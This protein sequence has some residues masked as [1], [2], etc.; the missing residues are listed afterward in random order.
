MNIK[1]NPQDLFSCH[2]ERSEGSSAQGKFRE[3]SLIARFFRQNTGGQV[4]SPRRI[5]LRGSFRMT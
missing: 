2:P 3:G 5:N 4:S 1:L